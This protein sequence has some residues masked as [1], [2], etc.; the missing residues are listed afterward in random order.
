M[1]RFL[2]LILIVFVALIV[3]PQLLNRGGGSNTLSASE[4]AA[5]TR[6]AAARIDRGQTNYLSRHGR[7]TSHLADL[8]LADKQLAAHLTVPLAVELDVGA[9]GKSYL[10]HVS[11]DVLSLARSSAGGKVRASSCRVLKS[12]KGVA[13]P[14][15]GSAEGTATT[16]KGG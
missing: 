12:S 9:D 5:L 16:T 1:R 13:C 10:A 11:S 14:E 15:A 7:Y 3:L 8:V 2:P 6:D 4:R